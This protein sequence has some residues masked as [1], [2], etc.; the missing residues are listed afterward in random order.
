MLRFGYTT[1]TEVMEHLKLKDS[2]VL[3]YPAKRYLGPTDKERIRFPSKRL[4]Q[5]AL[6]SFIFL[7]SAPLVGLFDWRSAERALAADVPILIIFAKVDEPG[8]DYLHH[9][10]HSYHDHGGEGEGSG[11]GSGE[12]VVAEVEAWKF[13]ALA[14]AVRAI[15]EAHRH[16]IHVLLGDKR[17]HTYEL[18]SYGLGKMGMDDH[19]VGLGIRGGESGSDHY[20][21]VL[22]KPFSSTPGETADGSLSATDVVVEALEYLELFFGNEL[23]PE[24][25]HRYD[26]HDYDY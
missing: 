20:S 17:Y 5:N 25:E 13:D 24:P 23:T 12:A 16:D 21:R 18:N 15:A 9:E 8:S 6:Q 10:H 22:S 7:E 19:S 11:E 1:S 4:Y 26:S 2:A 14:S 3:I